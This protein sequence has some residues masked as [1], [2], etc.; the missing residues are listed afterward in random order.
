MKKKMHDSSP[1]P[2]L[3]EPLHLT[4]RVV[5]HLLHLPRVAD[6][7]HPVNGD[8]SLGNVGADNDLA[9][10]LG[11]IVEDLLL[12]GEAEGAVERQHDPLVVQLGV[13]PA[14]VNNLG[15]EYHN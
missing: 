9:H 13:L 8:R 14:G 2:E 4:D 12:F 1:Y 11:R 5:G 3:L 7:A 15:T 6:K 10:P